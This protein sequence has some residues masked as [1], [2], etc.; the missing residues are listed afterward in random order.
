MLEVALQCE[1]NVLETDFLANHV[2]RRVGKAVVH[3]AHDAEQDRAVAY[4]GIKHAQRRRPRMHIGE[5]ER[6]SA[7]DHPLFAAGVDEQKVFLAVVEET[8]IALRICWHARF[9]RHSGRWRER[10]RLARRIDRA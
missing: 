7:R 5:L 10:A 1:A 8:E 9:R 2:E 4:P 6:H 3:R